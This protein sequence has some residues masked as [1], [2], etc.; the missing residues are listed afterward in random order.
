MASLGIY[1]YGISLFVQHD[2]CKI[3]SKTAYLFAVI[4]DV[5][6]SIESHADELF[7]AYAVTIALYSF[8]T[9]PLKV[10]LLSQKLV[11]DLI[12]PVVVELE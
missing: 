3:Y 10:T 7:P 2:C 11:L 4:E 6:T 8:P 5:S 9:V 1:L 12:I